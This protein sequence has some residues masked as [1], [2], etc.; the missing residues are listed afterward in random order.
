MLT[1]TLSHK[2]KKLAKQFPVISIGGPRQ[3]GKTTLARNIFDRHDYINLEDPQEREFARVDP[4]GF[5]R[6]FPNSVIL[7]EVQKA[8]QLLSHIQIEVD[9]HPK[10][11]RYILTGSQQIPF[12]SRIAQTLAGRTAI[13]N[14]LPFAVEEL[15]EYP[16]AE[17]PAPEILPKSLR[18]PLVS[19]DEVLY[20]GLYPPIHDRKLDAY[21]WLS[22]YYRTYVERD[23]RD[24][25]N[26]GDMDTFQRFI[27]LCAGRSG[28]LINYS[29]LAA[30]CGISH[31]TARN[32]LSVL[33]AGFI[34]HLLSPHHANFSKR[35]IKSPKLYFFDTGL[36]CYLLGIRSA[37][38]IAV[39]PLKGPI[40]ETFVV[41]E[42]YKAF[43]HRGQTPPL[44]F[45]RDKTG[46]EVD[47][48]IDR[49]TKLF[50][51]DVKAG[52]TVD[53]S[54]FSALRYFTT[55]GYPASAT[56]ALIY[57]GTSVYKR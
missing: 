34:I 1:R 29:S 52:E 55:L 27:R 41:A 35:L 26:I 25:A 22:A 7:D 20:Q 5:L 31:T 18:K 15:F 30:D 3:S 12:M 53:A 44:F 13:V 16:Y 21:D 23:V 24:V 36:L 48:I 28:Q 14:L 19:K 50:S 49:G 2:I 8:P 43:A 51:V 42:M 40:F 39:H 11:G 32:W 56:A 4:K 45:W 10:R 33:Q 46:H 57:G 47:L 6:R 38:Q 9:A 54:L 37:Q 17:A